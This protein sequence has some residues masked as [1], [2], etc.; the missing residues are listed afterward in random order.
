[1]QPPHRQGRLERDGIILSLDRGG[2]IHD[3]GKITPSVKLGCQRPPN[4]TIQTA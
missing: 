2:G 1:M 4:F 3:A